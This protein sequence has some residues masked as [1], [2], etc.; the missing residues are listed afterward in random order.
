M[1]QVL[2]AAAVAGSTSLV[3][4]HLF[5]PNADAPADP[6]SERTGNPFDNLDR[7]VSLTSALGSP[8]VPSGCND[9]DNGREGNCEKHDGIFRF[10]SSGAAS[11]SG[12][13]NCRKKVAGVKKIGEKSGC[14]EAEAE[15]EVPRKSARRFA[16]SLKRRKIGKNVAAKSGS[17][18]SKGLVTFWLEFQ[19]SYGCAFAYWRFNQD[20]FLNL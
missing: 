3:A 1:W 12:S 5:S 10:S 18:S 17:S 7:Q 19:A 13:R 8:P 15:A 16:V 6:G 4:K 2:L 14:V 11:P 20:Y 9:C